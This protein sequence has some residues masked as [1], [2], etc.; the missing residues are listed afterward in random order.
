MFLVHIYLECSL[1]IFTWNVPFS[2]KSNHLNHYNCICFILCPSCFEITCYI[3]SCVSLYLCVCLQ[4]DCPKPTTTFFF[5]V[6]LSVCFLKDSHNI[7]LSL[8][9]NI[10]LSEYFLHLHSLFYQWVILFAITVQCYFFHYRT[11]C[12]TQMWYSVQRWWHHR[13]D[14]DLPVPQSQ[15]ISTRTA[16][17]WDQLL[18]VK[19][20]ISSIEV[21]LTASEITFDLSKLCVFLKQESSGRLKNILIQK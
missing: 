16:Y 21:F 20:V 10:M 15:Y 6:L 18:Q 2:Y 9:G 12:L 3:N 17:A 19:Y 5:S 7:L 1:F 8:N 11:T 4:S 14:L 13:G